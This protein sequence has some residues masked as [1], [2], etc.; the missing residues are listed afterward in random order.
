MVFASVIA[1]YV[2]HPI[3]LKILV[4]TMGEN[5]SAL[6]ISLTQWVMI[7]LLFAY[8]R[9]HPVEKPETWPRFSRASLSDALSPQPM[10]DFVSLSLGGVLSLSTWWLQ[11]LASFLW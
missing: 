9:F 8:L 2:V 5:G 10:L 1:S 4:P 3:L 7:G 6:A 11:P